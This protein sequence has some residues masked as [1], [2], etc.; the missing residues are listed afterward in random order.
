MHDHES[1]ER[2]DAAVLVDVCFLIS[3]AAG[4]PGGDVTVVESAALKRTHPAKKSTLQDTN[5]ASVL[6]RSYSNMAI[7]QTDCGGMAQAIVDTRGSNHYL[8]VAS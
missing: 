3:A 6:R 5:S 7:G 2:G 4:R 1:I 8:G